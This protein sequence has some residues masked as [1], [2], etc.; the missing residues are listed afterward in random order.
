MALKV[1]LTN[2]GY[3]ENTVWVDRKTGLTLTKGAT[4][5][6]ITS[7]GDVVNIANAVLN[8]TLT[9]C[10]GTLTDLQTLTGFELR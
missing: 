6:D 2:M 5:D 8:G 7:L 9:L 4:S 3:W 1:T 10:E